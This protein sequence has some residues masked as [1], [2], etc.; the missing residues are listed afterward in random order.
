MSS[1]GAEGSVV[2]LHICPN[3]VISMEKN[4]IF[5]KELYVIFGWGRAEENQNNT[6]VLYFIIRKINS[7][8]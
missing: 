5:Q 6:N 4:H 1:W 7:F 8:I 2:R 3:K